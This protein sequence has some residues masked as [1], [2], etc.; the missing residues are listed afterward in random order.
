MSAQFYLSFIFLSLISGKVS[1]AEA[2]AGISSTGGIVKMVFGLLVVL[3][4]MVLATWVIKR[5]MPGAGGQQSVIRVVGG[6]SVGTRERVVVLEVAGRWLVVGVAP[7][8]VNAIANFEIDNDLSV[9]NNE[10]INMSNQMPQANT[11]SQSFTSAFG[12]MLKK[13]AEGFAERAN[14]K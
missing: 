7:G 1:A 4:V 5:M 10:N 8:Q 6:A 11:A 2:V 12:K 9:I 14:E 13:S 3:G